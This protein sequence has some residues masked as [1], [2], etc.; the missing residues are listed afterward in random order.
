MID[1]RFA[2]DYLATR[3]AMGYKLFYQGQVLPQFAAHLDAAG[4]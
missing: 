1:Y 2:V 4:A 3:R